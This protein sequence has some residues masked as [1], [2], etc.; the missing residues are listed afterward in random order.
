MKKILKIICIII[1]IFLGGFIAFNF[2]SH[3]TIKDYMF[4]SRTF[5]TGNMHGN[6]DIDK[7]SETNFP[8][9]KDLTGN[10]YLI[11]VG[12]FGLVWNGSIEDEMLLD[13]L[14]KKNFTILFV[15]GEHENFD[16]LSTYPTT[17]WNGGK[18]QKI[19]SNIY[20][21]MRGEIYTIN[22]KQFFV[23][24][25]GETE[26]KQLRK[27]GENYWSEEMPSSEDWTNAINN[28]RS[29]DYKVDYVL[30]QTPPSSDLKYIGAIL[31]RTLGQGNELNIALENLNEKIEY[32][33]WFHGYYN[34]D[35]EINKKDKAIFNDIIEL[36]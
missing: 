3:K 1:A 24:G 30:T 15:D 31:G 22:G 11:V 36:K 27:K 32:N 7:I 8:T 6:I 29:V 33:K 4:N 19:R 13:E 14:N 16:R 23:M 21:L 26:N 35:L 34:M 28:L 25:G 5:I 18:I 12:D 17:K 20:H 10:D 9:Q 2:F